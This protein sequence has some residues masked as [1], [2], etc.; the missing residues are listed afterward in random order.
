M[1]TELMFGYDGATS[2]CLNETALWA[3]CTAKYSVHKT[4]Y[5]Y[6]CLYI[7]ICLDKS[8]LADALSERKEALC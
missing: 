4:V 1:I 2:R 5:F 6:Q 3:G 8:K 7:Y